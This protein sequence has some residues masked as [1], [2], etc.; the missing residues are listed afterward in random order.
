M[1]RGLLRWL[2]VAVASVALGYAALLGFI[3]FVMSND[4][5][6][7]DCLRDDREALTTQ[8]AESDWTGR[9]PTSVE[10]RPILEGASQL[11][12]GCTIELRFGSAN[13]REE[14]SRLMDRA[15]A[16][17]GAVHVTRQGEIEVG[18]SDIVVDVRV[19]VDENELRIDVYVDQ[20]VDLQTVADVVDRLTCCGDG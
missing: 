14:R 17:G 15:E 12:T 13:P 18:V 5:T 11:Y 1:L 2:A 6:P 8:I 19:P 16:L 4:Q 7:G 20:D 10:R 9:P 3:V